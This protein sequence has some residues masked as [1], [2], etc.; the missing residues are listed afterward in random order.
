MFRKRLKI[1]KN[2]TQGNMTDLSKNKGE[3]YSVNVVSGMASI[4]KRAWVLYVLAY[5][6]N[7]T[8]AIQKWLGVNNP[9]RM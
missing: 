3:T 9:N 4:S 2:G 1:D 6:H 5:V 7:D 8:Q